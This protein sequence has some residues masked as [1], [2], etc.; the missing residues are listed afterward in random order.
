MIID[1]HRISLAVR[2]IAATTGV[3]FVCGCATGPVAREA[4]DVA[5]AH[6]LREARSFHFSTEERVADYL[7]AASLTAPRLGSGTERTPAREIYNASA[8]ELTILLRS[9]NA[10]RL[11]NHPL[12]ITSDSKTYHL[13]LV[14]AGP[15][16]WS[17]DFFTSFKDAKEVE[18]KIIK[19]KNEIAQPGV[20]GTLVGV[21]QSTPR[22]KFS[23]VKGF[24][25]PV[26]ATI[27]FSGSNATIALRRPTKD[28]QARIE[29]RLRPLAADFS[30]P[31]SYYRPPANLLLV[32]LMGGM[33]GEN[34]A[35]RNGLFFLQPYDPDRI[36]VV[37]VHGLFSTPF[38]WTQTINGLQAD[39]AIRKR[40]QFWVFSYSTGNPILYSALQLRE[41][42]AGVDKAYP[43]H[44]PY[45]LVGHS[46]GGI[47]SH[48][49]V[50]TVTRAMWE[51][52]LGDTARNIFARNANN[53][54]VMNA[55]IFNA[56]PRVKRVVFVCAP[57]R[58]STLATSGFGRLG[59]SLISLPLKIATTMT[60]ALTGA[61]LTQLTGSSK[62]LPNSITGLKPTNPT[63][64]VVNSGPITTPYHSIIGDRG[65]GDSPNSTDG[66]VPYW[67]SHFGG[68]KSEC[69]VPG[70]HSSCELPQTIT[71]LDRILELHIKSG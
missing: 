25:A 13:E 61:E 48:M 30:A 38:T 66:V 16:V 28:L 7:D 62:R 35:E 31:I 49:Q 12:T 34:Y 11:W 41:Q 14:P 65:K 47:I 52:K 46:M 19:R 51:K 43:N 5:A 20:G 15:A 10:G 54:L 45:I 6:A 4:P 44:K 26:T 2:L 63:F 55:M 40:Y 37:F 39:P 70:P 18:A 33:R 24:T 50:T 22:E 29:G 64:E 71:E 8:T 27:D 53:A 60:G 57:H 23:G 59:I 3:A 69:I 58:G 1:R 9:E 36:P 42:L 21:R 17:P 32:G 56:N 68:A 67:S